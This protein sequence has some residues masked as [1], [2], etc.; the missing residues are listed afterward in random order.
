MSRFPVHALE[1]VLVHTLDP[2][3]ISVKATTNEK[4]GHIGNS[5][6]IASIAVCQIEKL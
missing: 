2:E 4:L 5:E 3:Q 6:S 1:Y